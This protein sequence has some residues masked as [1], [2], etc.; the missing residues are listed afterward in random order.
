MALQTASRVIVAIKAEDT[1]GVAASAGGATK[2]RIIDSPGLTLKRALIQSM[3]KRA[4]GN[5]STPRLGYKSVDGSHTGELTIGGAI[6]MLLEGITRSSFVTSTA[7][8]FA[9]VTSVTVGTNQVVA[10]AG[11]W[12]GGQ[13]IRVGD[14]FRLSNYS[15]PADNDINGQVIAISSLTLTVASGTFPTVGAADTAGT[16]TVLRKLVQGTTPTR[17]SYSVDQHDAIVT[18]S[19]LFVGCRVVKVDLDFTAGQP[20]KITASWLGMDRTALATGT[21]PYFT[22]PTAT[23]GLALIPED[24][25]IRYN[26]ATVTTFTGLKVSFEITAAGQPVI[27]SLVTPDIFDNDLRV[28][29]Q[30]TG[31]RSDFSNLTAFDAETALELFMKLEE[32][33]STPKGC[34]ALYLPN[35]KIS[36]LSAPVGGGD[37]A[38]IETLDFVA[39]PK[40]AATGYDGTVASFSASAV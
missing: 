40:V 20:G 27:G 3:E 21:S 2:F 23:T 11:D 34:F 30:I 35:V 4:D 39:S 18:L 36:A 25:S 12:V 16:L 15:T 6:N 26:G 28:T 19:E 24:S 17:K 32:P 7:I 29:G 38:K 1:T 9:S 31:L 14:V 33:G 5:T 13:G 37:G 8:G 22:S 10:A